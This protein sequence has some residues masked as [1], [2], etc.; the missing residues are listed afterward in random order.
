MRPRPL[1]V[2]ASA[3]LASL[4]CSAQHPSVGKDA[5]PI[6]AASWLNWKGDAPTLESLKGRVVMLEFW[7]TW[8]G[9]CVRAMPGVQKL[10]DRY[11]DRG[12]TV[13]AISYETNDKLQPFLTQ[14]AFTM[15]V[16]SDPDKKTIGAYPINGWPTTIIIGKDGKIAH[17]GSP[18]DAEA[19]VEKALGLEAGEGAVLTAYFEAQKEADKQKKRDAIDRLVEKATP[20][21]DVAAWA[22]GHLPAEKVADGGAPAPAPAPATPAKP[23]VKPGNPVEALGKCSP[24]WADAAQR[25][26]VLQQLALVTEPIDLAAFAQQ[27]MA[28][29]FPFDAAELNALLKE[30]KYAAVLDAIGARAPAAAVLSAAAKNA[31]LAAFCK[32]KAGEVRTNAKKAIMA[33]QYVFANAL[34][35]DQ[36][37]NKK[38]WSEL[39]VSGMATS[40]DK[41]Q[42]TGIL[43]GGEQLQRD[44]ATAFIRSQLARTFLMEDLGAGK[45]PRIKELPKLVDDAKKE[46]VRDLESR[47]GKPEPFVPKE[48]PKK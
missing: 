10:H 45:P 3:L 23:A 12:L 36:E 1:L 9:P 4:P 35:K 28:K 20:K 44:H 7:G 39:S 25:T 30:K 46:I 15:P 27:A 43:L 19:A 40:P 42:I 14:N 47:Y 37:V 13:L 16:G 22:K 32:S 5:P 2:L 18:Y 21:F 17:V 34:P 6:Q 33:Q 26:A 41:K 29:A 24:V 31:D 48:E 38:F 11:T 8:C